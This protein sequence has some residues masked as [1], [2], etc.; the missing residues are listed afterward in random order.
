MS[1]R[2]PTRPTKEYSHGQVQTDQLR[3][4]PKLDHA[5]VLKEELGNFKVRISDS[6]HDSYGAGDDWRRD[7]YHNDDMVLSVAMGVWC[8]KRSV[9]IEFTLV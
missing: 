3:V 7:G 2:A 6:G 5:E 1:P 9:P 4:S 8:A